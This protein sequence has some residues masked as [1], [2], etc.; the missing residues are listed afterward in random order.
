MFCATASSRACGVMYRPP[1]PVVVFSPI[2]I[3]ER[4]VWARPRFWTFAPACIPFSSNSCQF[5]TSTRPRPE[6]RHQVRRN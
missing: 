6:P 5:F 4:M 2:L 3:V 1:R